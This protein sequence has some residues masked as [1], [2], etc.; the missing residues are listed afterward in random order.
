MS[1]AW[2]LVYDTI[3]RCR[4]MRTLPRTDADV[5]EDEL[6]HHQP[7]RG[8]RETWLHDGTGIMKSLATI[9]Y[10]CQTVARVQHMIMLTLNEWT[11]PSRDAT[12]KRDEANR[13]MAMVTSM[14]IN[15]AI[16]RIK[17]YERAF[18]RKYSQSAVN[19][20]LLAIATVPD[21]TNCELLAD[22]G[23]EI[24]EELQEFNT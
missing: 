7:A 2:F 24:V 13:T 6:N 20:T 5:L 21:D 12:V 3:R 19:F 22:L 17:S 1:E 4:Y 10:Q 15:D 23:V 9:G 18:K 14:P 8:T 16:L 11:G